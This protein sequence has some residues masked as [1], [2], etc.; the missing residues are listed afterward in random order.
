MKKILFIT[1]LI[2]VLGVTY[3]LAKA[4]FELK[5]VPIQ[6]LIL[7]G[8]VISPEGSSVLEHYISGKGGILELS[9]SYLQ[10]SPVVKNAVKGLKVG[11]SR[12]ITFKQSQDWRLSYALNPF[13]IK[14]TKDGYEITQYIEFDRTNK[15][16]TFL[17]LG[18]T[19][20]KVYD[21]LVHAYECKPFTVKCKLQKI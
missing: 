17:N 1:L 20:L 19:K 2:P 16:Y 3:L 6:V 15:V 13:N 10:T 21:N 12:R 18:F 5:K 9:P 8:K 11:E 4:N 14:R 7:G